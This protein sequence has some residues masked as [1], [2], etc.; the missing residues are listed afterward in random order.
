MDNGRRSLPHLRMLAS[1]GWPNFPFY[2]LAARLPMAV[3]GG[4]VGKSDLASLAKQ[5]RI[6]GFSCFQGTRASPSA[7]DPHEAAGR[8]EAARRD[9]P[10]AGRAS[11]RSGARVRAQARAEAARDRGHDGDEEAAGGHVPQ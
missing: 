3:I 9:E 6:N 1:L 2:P 11:G 10:E 8:Q 4:G 7:H 5:L